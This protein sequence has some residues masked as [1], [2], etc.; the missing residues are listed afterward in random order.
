MGQIKTLLH[1]QV[2]T[3][4]RSEQEGLI[5]NLSVFPN[6]KHLTFQLVDHKT[7]AGIPVSVKFSNYHLKISLDKKR[8]PVVHIIKP[9]LHEKVPHVYKSSNNALCLY[10]KS[11]FCWNTISLLVN[12][13]VP[14]IYF[15]V[16][17]YE[18]WLI[19]GKW[20][21]PEFDHSKLNTNEK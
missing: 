11:E 10:H 17:F 18:K 9:F 13:I 5:T 16:Y 21:G 7:L 14:W 12:T 15:W 2:N 19:T 8:E 3:M 1:L 6:N 4:R 20:L